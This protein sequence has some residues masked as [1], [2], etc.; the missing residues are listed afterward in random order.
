[1]HVGRRQD[2]LRRL[3]HLQSDRFRRLQGRVPQVREV[4]DDEACVARTQVTQVLEHRLAVVER[5][6]RVHHHDEVERPGQ[7]ADERGV[8]DVTDQEREI[9]MGLARLRDHSRAEIYTHPERRL[10]C[11]QQV[12]G[13][14][15]ELEH[16]CAFGNE[17]LEI[18]QI[19][20]VKE[21]AAREPFATRG[22]AGV[23]EA[24]DFA[25]AR[26]DVAAAVE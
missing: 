14:A 16:A 8:L 7:R 18:E 19:L 5:T 24:P 26:R 25:L 6:E 17:E 9:G 3:R 13:A 21:R 2:I 23:G 11:G 1:M 20:I 22:R 4:A 12:A 15:S 10:E